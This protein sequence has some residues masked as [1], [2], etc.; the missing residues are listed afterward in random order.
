LLHDGWE[1]ALSSELAVSE[2]ER[3]HRALARLT[4]SQHDRLLRCYHLLLGRLDSEAL[5]VVRSFLRELGDENDRLEVLAGTKLTPTQVSKLLDL[6]IEAVERLRAPRRD[7][8][9][10]QHTKMMLGVFVDYAAFEEMR[11]IVVEELKRDS[12]YGFWTPPESPD[13]AMPAALM[14]MHAAHTRF[15]ATPPEEQTRSPQAAIQ[16][17][18]QFAAAGIAVGAQ[19]SNWAL[20]RSLPDLL[21]PFACLSPVVDAIHENCLAV[22]E[23]SFGRYER[24]RDRTLA[25]LDRLS[26]GDAQSLPYVDEIRSALVYG[27]ASAD[28]RIGTPKAFERLVLLESHPRL[29]ANAMDLK[30]YMLL[31]QGDW[32]EAAA[33]YRMAEQ[34]QMDSPMGQM[35]GSKFI[36]NEA[37]IYALGGDLDGVTRT[38]HRLEALCSKYPGW[39]PSLRLAQAEQARLRGEFD[40]A[41]EAYGECLELIQPLMT[42]EGSSP[43]WYSATAGRIEVLLEMR[44]AEEATEVGRRAQDLGLTWRG[45]DALELRFHGIIRALALAES[46]LGD[47]DAALR[48]LEPV[49]ERR[50]QLGTTGLS[51]GLLYEARALIAE[52]AGSRALQE[53]STQQACAQFSLVQDSA[54]FARAERL[55]EPLADAPQP[56]RTEEEPSTEGPTRLD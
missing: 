17:L 24:Y 11:P 54:F 32:K 56:P 2:S 5:D 45:A 49:I 22:K 36:R 48:R 18:V 33:C 10:L 29:R 43:E 8:S 12:G 35:F 16:A 37:E 50:Q 38:I 1:K 23:L 19:A 20:R 30:A 34:L 52:Q 14:A 13:G 27:A 31:Q 39:Q 47:H 28:A 3:L 21:R 44:R 40:E 41:L 6:S 55:R 42:D 46:R 26:Q 15:E 25:V 9:D 7:L 53:Q 4:S 51:L